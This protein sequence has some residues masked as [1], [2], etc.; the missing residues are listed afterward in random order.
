MDVGEGAAE[1]CRDVE[2]NY[3]MIQPAVDLWEFAPLTWKQW[4]TR[5]R[6]SIRVS[7]VTSRI[8]QPMVGLLLA[9]KTTELYISR[10]EK[11]KDWRDGKRPEKYAIGNRMMLVRLPALALSPKRFFIFDGHHRLTELKP[12]IILLD[13]ICVKPSEYCYVTDLFNP[14]MMALVE[15]AR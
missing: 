15:K 12:R 6:H 14:A 2:G 7:L 13:W 8:K 4:L 5:Y 1:V 9:D 10:F 3:G 11:D